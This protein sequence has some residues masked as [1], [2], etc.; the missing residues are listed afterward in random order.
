MYLKQ[1]VN[2]TEYSRSGGCGCK[3]PPNILDKILKNLKNNFLPKEIS[4]GVKNSDDAAVYTLDK[5]KSLVLTT[6]F[7]VPIVDNPKH[8][9]QISAANAISD[10]YAMG[11]QPIMAL[12]ILGIP[13]NEIKVSVLKKI[14][15][16]AGNICSKAGIVI[17]GGHTI[18]LKEPIFGLV[19]L[20][21]V[22]TKRLK[23]NNNSKIDD[24]LILT[25]PVGL[26]I[27][28]SAIKKKKISKSEYKE[29]I[30]I[31]T[32]LNEIGIKLSKLK[33][34]NALT[35]V[36]GFG[37]LG[38]LSEV[39]IASKV[40]AE[41]EAEK[42]PFLSSVKKFILSDI[43]TGASLRN[44]EHYKRRILLKSSNNNFYKKLL[45]D[46]QTS[47]GLIISVKKQKSKEIIKILKKHKFVYADIIGKIKKYDEKHLITV[48]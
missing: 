45:T 11:G 38:H 30:S 34:V 17:A 4:V 18:E 43:F 19:V 29:F 2:L 32:Q 28:A 33:E 35:D 25:K 6:D 47:G 42:I 22:K 13:T 37:L 48:I 10:I 40:S 24:H 7:F 3:I 15:D 9:G 8:F 46:P 27:Y 1:V 5:N 20:G 16:G 26:G 36:T 23:K 41:I 21:I 14:I 44:W 31:T 12:S 39:C